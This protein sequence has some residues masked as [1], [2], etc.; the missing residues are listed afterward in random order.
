MILSEKTFASIKVKQ[1][2]S[3]NYKEFKN[4]CKDLMKVY[5]IILRLDP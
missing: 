3:M 2:L 1:Q 4:G 5:L